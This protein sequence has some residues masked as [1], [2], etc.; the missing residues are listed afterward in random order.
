MKIKEDAESIST[1]DFWYDLTDGGYIKPENFLDDSE[2]ID[3][4]YDAI[5]LL[6]SFRDL[7]E[8]SGLL[9]EI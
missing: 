6:E 1:D 3:S 7:L 5:N 9:E 4:I 2:D 8:E